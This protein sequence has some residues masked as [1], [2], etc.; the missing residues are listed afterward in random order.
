MKFPY[1]YFSCLVV[2]IGYGITF[3][4][5]AFLVS[6]T[7]VSGT[8]VGVNAALPAVGWILGSIL[9]P[10]LQL[11][12]ALPIKR[13]AVG[14]LCLAGAGC[15]IPVF[16]DDYLGLSV[17]RFIFGGAI[18]VF[19]RCVEYIL[20]ANTPDDRRGKNLAI[21]GVCF[22]SGII[23]GSSIQPALGNVV[24][25]NAVAVFALIA[26][27]CGIFARCR[28][29]DVTLNTPKI[30][31]SAL[32]LIPIVPIAFLGVGA[33]AFYESVPA[34]LL[35]VY[36]LRN[37][38][39]DA[40][41]AFTLSAAALGQLLFLFPILLLSDRLGRANVLGAC[42]AVAVLL[43][44]AITYTIDASTIFLC[45]IA[46][47]GAAAGASYGLS[48]AML[49][50][51]FDGQTLVLANALFGVIYASASVAGPLIHGAS[52]EFLAPHGLM[53]SVSAIFLFLILGMGISVAWVNFRGRHA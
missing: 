20:V 32:S 36:A 39:D 24:S 48:L 15:C 43:P 23:I 40:I 51:R 17:T 9:V 44:F 49:G 52:M 1:I 37:G 22:L 38:V 35:Q 41:A 25:T 30:T 46:V 10:F 14:F 4:H 18:G 13:I 7:G 33:Y 6:S 16:S 26:V 29:H 34:Y 27:G 47:L 5:Y 2:C 53:R 28:V 11:N 8:W 3:S 21:Y 50:D 12:L 45:L 19:F 42:A 31:K